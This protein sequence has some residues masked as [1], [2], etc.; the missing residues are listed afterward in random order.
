MSKRTIYVTKPTL[1]PF[2]EFV[3]GLREIWD[4]HTLTNFGP[5]NKLLVDRLKQYLDVPNISLFVNGHQALEIAIATMGL[6]GEVITTPFSFAST[7]HAIVRNGWEPVFCDIDPVTFNLDENLIESLITDRTSAILPVHVYGTPCNVDRISDIAKRYN[8]KVIYDAAHA[9]GV[10][11]NGRGI[12]NF[13][14]MSM[15]S[16]HATKV[17]NTIE[18]GALT[19]NDPSYEREVYLRQNFGIANADEVVLP[20]TNAKMN[21]IQSLVGLLNLKYI[22][23]EIEKRENAVNNYRR[24]LSSIKG[25]QFRPEPSKGIKLTHTYFPILVTPEYGKT[26]DELVSFLQE[27]NIFPRKYFYP[28]I[29]EYSCYKG[30]YRGTTPI[31]KAISD[32]VLCLPLWSNICSG[33]IELICSLID[34]GRK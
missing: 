8:L 28:L 19:Y 23:Q 24:L 16:F 33:E 15:F 25:I 30:K 11:I 4:N 22:E 32:Q 26:R 5:V 14:D 2:N 34:Q 17:F 1:P 13:G 12:G 18:G 9:F 20:G 3:E 7:T 31:A 21:E 27:N 29:S 6:S 10:T